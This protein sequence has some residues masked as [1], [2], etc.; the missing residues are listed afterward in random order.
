[1]NSKKG[2]EIILPNE[3]VPHLLLIFALGVTLFYSLWWFDF[4][5]V[6]SW[7]LYSLLFIGEI[8]HIWQAVGY[9]YT[10]RAPK[11]YTAEILPA[12]FSPKVDLF[13][14][15]CGEP[16]EIVEKTLTAAMTID[17]Q[18][19]QVFLLNDG[20]V[21]KKENWQEIEELAKR[22]KAKV[23]TRLTPGG[24]KA[25]NINNALRQTN[26]PFIAFFDADHIPKKDFLNK[27]LAYFQ[28][29]KM[30]L[31]QTPQYYRNKDQNHLT[32]S[33]WEQQELFFGPICQGKNKDNA[34]FWCGTNAVIKREALDAVGGLLENT[35]TED[36]LVSLYLHQKGYKSIYVPEI[37]S[38][39]LAPQDLK[40]YV[41]QQYRW[42]RGCLDLIF[43][44]NPIFKKGLTGAQKIH[45][46]YSSSYYLNGIIVAVNAL[47][48]IYVLM[49]GVS[50]IKE[51]VN[52]FMVYFF[53]FIFT[54][55]YILM[56]S[57]QFKITFNAIQMSI[58]S[59]FVFIIAAV[60]TLLNIKTKFKVTS[61][62]EESGNYLIYAI[63]HIAYI[64]ITIF[65][66]TFAV[67][68]QGITPSVA[69]NA[70]WSFF[71]I[72]FFFGF[73]RVAYP[74]QTLTVPLKSKIN[75]LYAQTIDFIKT[76]KQTVYQINFLTGR[77]NQK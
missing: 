20:F 17:Y 72:V 50:P 5:N 56:K 23:I 55:I 53:P 6:Q 76:K 22:Y 52:N 42:A 4:S 59:T 71:N 48:P 45:Y 1:M 19:Y 15:V 67:T 30:A 11:K 25:G 24:A 18:N 70:S 60:S 69:T 3:Q 26:A 57:T 29:H 13:I 62:M 2:K 58:S 33:A 10:I 38:E 34:T 65:A 32:S 77:H 12:S 28:D 40:S 66:V 73:I 51:N 39:G 54:T 37:L 44:H 41:S 46:L 64:L 31:V 16:V 61:K 75:N 35:V 63:P 8:Y 74:W 43:N 21:A 68:K 36:F 27:T 14:T 49:T 9:M 7:T 47:I